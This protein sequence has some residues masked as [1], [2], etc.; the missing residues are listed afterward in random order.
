MT[1]PQFYLKGIFYF[2]ILGNI[3][4]VLWYMKPTAEFLCGWRRYSPVN[5]NKTH[6]WLMRKETINDY[7]IPVKYY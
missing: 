6:V 7:I 4:L 3:E 1:F 5:E 2:M